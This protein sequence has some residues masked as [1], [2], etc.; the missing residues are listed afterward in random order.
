LCN[1]LKMIKKKNHE[2]LSKTPK[3]FIGD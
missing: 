3:T 1:H 2:Q